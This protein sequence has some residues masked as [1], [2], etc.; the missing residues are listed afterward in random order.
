MTGMLKGLR[1]Q[2]GIG[3]ADK[4]YIDASGVAQGGM[5]TTFGSVM[6]SQGMKSTAG[7]AG[8]MLAQRGLLGSSRGTWGGVGMGALGGAG[9]G[10]SVGGPIGAVVGA[11]VG[12]GIGIGEKAAGVET[13]QNEAKRLVKS[14]YGIS[15]NNS[16][17]NSIVQLAQ[18]K[19]GNT[20]SIAVRSPEV[21]QML[22]LY[23]QG[24]GQKMAQSADMPHGAGLVESGGRLAQEQMYQYGVGH[25]YSSN[26]PVE[27]SGSGSQFPSGGTGNVAMSFNIEGS[28]IS[29]FMGS[30]VF[31]P[32]ATASNY[33][34]S[35]AASNGR[36]DAAMQLSEAG[37]IVA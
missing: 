20:V 34:A 16:M 7:A 26:L 36:T 9:V 33:A 4:S 30:Q 18:S 2:W 14:Q 35:L 29:R 28:D 13:P 1:G 27:G 5:G 22:G 12:A 11:A 25:T 15:I 24:T 37:S 32:S 31:T 8:M 3:G 19:Y 17:A 21:R 23:A 10:F 6:N